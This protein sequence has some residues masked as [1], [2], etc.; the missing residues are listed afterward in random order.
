MAKLI[1]IEGITELR[2][3]LLDAYIKIKNKEITSEEVGDISRLSGKII[4][5]AKTQL[6]YHMHLGKKIKI[7]FL[8]K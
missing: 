1:K 2:N 4:S 6:Q 8:E 7:P 5:S 3:D